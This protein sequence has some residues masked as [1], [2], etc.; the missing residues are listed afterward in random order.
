M[1]LIPIAQLA[2]Y[3]RRPGVPARVSA[4]DA[5]WFRCP[6]CARRGYD[7]DAWLPMTD[8]FWAT[9]RGRLILS[10]CKACRADVSRKAR[11]IVPAGRRAMAT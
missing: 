2:D 11:G 8:E 1:Q 3:L 5:E 6:R 4:E 9:H 7:V 10:A